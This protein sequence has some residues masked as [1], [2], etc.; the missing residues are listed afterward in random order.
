MSAAVLRARGLSRQY[1][2][3][4]GFVRAVDGVDLDVRPGT[5]PT[6]CPAGSGSGSRSPGR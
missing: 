3:D 4:D 2:S 1:G 6:S 5:G